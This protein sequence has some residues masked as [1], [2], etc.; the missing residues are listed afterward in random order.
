MVI[1]A[2]QQLDN[3]NLN[4][5][6]YFCWVYYFFST[7]QLWAFVLK[8]APALPVVF[9]RQRGVHAVFGIHVVLQEK[10]NEIHPV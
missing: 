7:A 3:L 9:F 1:S 2:H 10:S 4:C 6:V 8:L 5:Y